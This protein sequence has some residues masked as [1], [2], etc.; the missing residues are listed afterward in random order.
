[1]EELVI[2]WYPSRPLSLSSGT[3]SVKRLFCGGLAGAAGGD[4]LGG[5]AAVGAKRT[6]GRVCTEERNHMKRVLL[7][8]SASPH[9]EMVDYI[10]NC[11]KALK[12]TRITAVS[13]AAS[14]FDLVFNFLECTLSLA[15]KH[16]IISNRNY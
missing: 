6:G 12:A 4:T 2:T 3:S 10:L 14:G 11:I 15:I 8:T 16:V 7:C 13:K 1:M 5:T 9:M